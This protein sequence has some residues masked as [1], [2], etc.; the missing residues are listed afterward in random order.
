MNYKKIHDRIISRAKNRKKIV[1][2]YEKHHIIPLCIDKN[3]KEVVN[4]TAKE[5]YLIHRLLVKIYSKSVGLK[6][7][8]YCMSFITSNKGT[9]HK[10]RVSL[11][12]YEESKLAASK[13][14]R[15]I[16]NSMYGKKNINRA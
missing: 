12:T 16:N 2:Y 4:L 11:K 7:A 5:H 9:K 8:Y 15:G 13:N 1:G 14:S 6:T 3:S 10:Y